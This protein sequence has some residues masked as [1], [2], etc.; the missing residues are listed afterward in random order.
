[1]RQDLH[2]HSIVIRNNRVFFPDLFSRCLACL[3]N[4][5]I[6]T[7]S[8]SDLS[9][10]CAEMAEWLEVAA[11]ENM[12]QRLCALFL[13]VR[14]AQHVGLFAE[15]WCDVNGFVSHFGLCFH[16]FNK[17]MIS[18]AECHSAF[19]PRRSNKS[20]SDEKSGVRSVIFVSFVQSSREGQQI[21]KQK[22]DHGSNSIPLPGQ[23][24]KS[25]GYDTENPL[26]E[27]RIADRKF[28]AITKL[29]LMGH[30]IKMWVFDDFVLFPYLY[31]LW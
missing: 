24:L 3:R 26:K 16:V 15:I 29:Q 2:S 8:E 5:A 22:S 4:E 30:L 31:A 18:C 25:W 11:P 17:W 7:F 20:R 27:L 14:L 23:G 28:M 12:E 10:A 6:I 21:S 13:A 1:M 9:F 19:R